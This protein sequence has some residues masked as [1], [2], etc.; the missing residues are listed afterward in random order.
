M[1]GVIMLYVLIIPTLWAI[2]SAKEMRTLAGYTR[3]D[4][5]QFKLNATAASVIWLAVGNLLIIV[6]AIVLAVAVLAG[7][8]WGV[9]S[10]GLEKS[11]AMAIRLAF[12]M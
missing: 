2:Y 9:T 4:G 11:T 12:K 6:L 1:I 8:F 10:L 7:M 3:F 5:A